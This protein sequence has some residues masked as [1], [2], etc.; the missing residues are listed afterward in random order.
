MLQGLGLGVHLAP[1]QA[2]HARQKQLHQAVPANDA[3]GLGDSFRGQLGPRPGLVVDPAR[4]LKAFEHAG[5]RRRPDLQPGR[6]VHRRHHL[7]RPAQ[8]VDGFEV[9]LHGGG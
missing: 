2:E 9:I 7:L 1:V 6:D 5:H 3:P 8:R 4:F